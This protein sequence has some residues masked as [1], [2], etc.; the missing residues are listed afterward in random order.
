M[1]ILKS[2]KWDEVSGYINWVGGIASIIALIITLNPKIRVPSWIQDVSPTLFHFL[3]L[4]KHSFPAFITGL[5]Y[6]FFI[7]FSSIILGT[8]LGGAIALVL[9]KKGSDFFFNAFKKI[10]K[11][12]VY[13]FLAVPALVL[14]VFTAYNEFVKLSSTLAAVIALSINLSPF[15]SRII[16]SGIKNVDRSYLVAAKSFGYSPKQILFKFKLP[17]IVKLSL[18]P[19]L[20]QWITTI[21]LSSL[22]SIIGVTE[23]L[24]QGTNIISETYDTEESYVLVMIYYGIII[25]L[26]TRLVDYID[27]TFILKQK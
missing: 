21:K 6:T 22:A 11:I 27:K 4:S 3:E 25:F 1:N 26:F 24:F 18:Q 12:Y 23:L 8:M 19:L 16:E 14:L 10:L 17:L 9:S 2:K 15:A 13:I 5:K 7:S 20:V